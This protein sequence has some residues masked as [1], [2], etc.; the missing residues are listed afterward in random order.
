ST[1]AVSYNT[2]DDCGQAPAYS[3]ERWNYAFWRQDETE[4][5]AADDNDEGM[6]TLF[7]WYK[8]NGV[9]NIGF[10]DYDNEY[11]KDMNYI[12]KGPVGYYE[13]LTAVSKVARRMQTEGFIAGKF[14]SI[15]IIVHE[16]EYYGL[17][18]EATAHANPN[19]EADL[20]LEAVKRGFE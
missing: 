18:E 2:E 5:I 13:L 15:P 4:I 1:F 7:Q 9:E 10:E 12:G 6:K 11:D 17:I 20:F 8:E 19:G 3:E 16:L 14:G